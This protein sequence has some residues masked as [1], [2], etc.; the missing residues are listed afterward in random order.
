MN[1]LLNDSDCSALQGHW[2]HTTLETCVRVHHCLC[3]GEQFLFGSAKILLDYTNMMQMWL[4]EIFFCDLYVSSLLRHYMKSR[5]DLLCWLSVNESELWISLRHR[6]VWAAI[7]YTSIINLYF[8]L[9]KLL[10]F[11]KSSRWHERIESLSEPEEM[12]AFI[13][14]KCRNTWWINLY[15]AVRP[16]FFFDAGLLVCISW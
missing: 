14:D 13:K 4:S 16:N 5:I 8:S 1:S 2:G 3:Q 9:F 6:S 10:K 11:S 12:S 15:W 7:C